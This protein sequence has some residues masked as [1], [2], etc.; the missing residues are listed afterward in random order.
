[1]GQ[2]PGRQDGSRLPVLGQVRKTTKEHVNGTPSWQSVVVALAIIG[3]VGLF[4]VVGLTQTEDVDEFLKL[5]GGLGTIVGVVAGA[6][7]SFFF[8]MQADKAVA[9]ADRAIS[10]AETATTT[11]MQLSERAQALAGVADAAAI[12]RA[13]EMAPQAFQDWNPRPT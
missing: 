10:R 1:M 13:V 11:A 9:Q 2:A 4:F 12:E 5:W 6:I 3:L 7:P 8:K